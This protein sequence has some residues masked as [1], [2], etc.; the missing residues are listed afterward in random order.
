MKTHTNNLKQNKS[1]AI[2]NNIDLNKN[3]QTHQ[4]YKAVQQRKSNCIQ[5]FTMTKDGVEGKVSIIDE[6]GGAHNGHTIGKHVV[7]ETEAAARLS[8]PKIP[9]SGFWETSGDAH[10]AF[11]KVLSED[12]TLK[13]WA[14]KSEYDPAQTEVS[15]NG[16]T[17]AKI[18]TR[19]GKAG[20]K[21]ELTKKAVGFIRK[22]D[23]NPFTDKN[24]KKTLGLVTLYPVPQ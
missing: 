2:A 16:V 18:V 24:D 22:P 15:T 5:R 21:T 3:N 20:T 6:E 12:R 14:G 17:G 10:S 7:K 9:A 1:R 8:D 23:N 13:H 4:L 11:K 19:D